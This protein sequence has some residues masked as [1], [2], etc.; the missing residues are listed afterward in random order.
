VVDQ[1]TSS[2]MDDLFGFA[3]PATETRST[4]QIF[5]LVPSEPVV[6][7]GSRRELRHAAAPSPDAPRR[8]RRRAAPTRASAPRQRRDEPAARKLRRSEA[9]LLREAAPKAS[10]K[11]PLSVLATM[12]VIGGL[13]A[14]AALP[15]YAMS[16]PDSN[17]PTAAAIEGQTIVVSAD[18]L[19][20]TAARD[21]YHATTPEQLAQ[22]TLN[23]IR[24]ANSAAYRLSGARELGD[25]YPWYYELK[26][27]QG[28]G[29]S[30]LNYYY[31]EC[32]D[33]V[34]WR[35]NRDAGSY[36]E[37]FK[38]V[39]ANLTPSGGNASQWKYSWDRLGRTSSDIPIVGS[40]AWFGYQNHVAYV[41]QVNEDG[42]VLIEEYN[43]F[44]GVYSQRTIPID[45]VDKFLYPP[46]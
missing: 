11:N 39:W 22:A 8:E 2:D 44:P 14:V 17:A 4:S 25:D 6:Q 28:G 33:F 35:L 26:A 18:A 12:T 10:R 20:Q 29:L 30:P 5:P 23:G 46:S 15:A 34:A 36:E 40:V 43:F 7:Y 42:T 27:S 21:G 32:V 3:H 16:T 37:P 9:A 41:K 24:A 38:Y 31:R 13:F 1:T 19:T 45:S